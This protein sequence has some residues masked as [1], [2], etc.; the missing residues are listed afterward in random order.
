ML[1]AAADAARGSATKVIA[2]T[3]LTALGDADLAAIG[4]RGGSARDHVLRLAE[5]AAAASLDGVVASPGRSID[6]SCKEPRKN[7]W[8]WVSRLVEPD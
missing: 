6:S 7:W 4:F 1:R 8:T 5:L 2:V 3:V